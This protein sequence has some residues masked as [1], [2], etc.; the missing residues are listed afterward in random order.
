MMRIVSGAA[1]VF[2]ITA[3]LVRADASTEQLQRALKDQGFYYGE[4]TGQIDADTTAAI[5]RFQIRNGLKVSGEMDAETRKALGL[6]AAASAPKPATARPAMPQPTSTPETADLRDD[7]TPQPQVQR[8]LYPE[9][10]PDY[11][12]APPQTQPDTTNI[13]AGTPFEA[14]P[15]PVQERVIVGAQTLLARSGYYRSGVDGVFGPGTAAAVRAYQAR[16]GLEPTGM[17][18]M[19]TLSALGLLPG[20]ERPGFPPRRRFMRPPAVEF[21]PDGEPIYT[22]R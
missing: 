17:L 1:A 8:R 3:S 9:P 16:V 14:A 4:I 10:P 12:P 18:D 5:R 19:D 15:P 7:S 2:F 6:S 22:P 20:Q 21:T 11:A 13:F